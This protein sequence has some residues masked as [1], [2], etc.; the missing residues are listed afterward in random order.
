MDSYVHNRV[1]STSVYPNGFRFILRSAKLFSAIVI[2]AISLF[3]SAPA[4]SAASKDYGKPG[5]PIQLVIGYQPYYTESWSGVIMRDKKFY[6][7]Y[8]PK[9]SSVEFQI[10][11]QGAIIVNGMLAGKVDIGYAGDMPSI[12]A[13]SHSDVRD[14]RI[15]SVLGIGF[16]Q[17]NAF[18]VRTDAPKFS[19][20]R[21][22]S[23]TLMPRSMPL[24]R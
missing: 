21:H 12:V 8:L 18:L 3:V 15:V 22:G 24:Q 20:P 5:E 16:D 4:E 2:G 6:E 9:G 23:R 19:S 17:C 1:R 7:K 10:G 11:L 13:T 14:I